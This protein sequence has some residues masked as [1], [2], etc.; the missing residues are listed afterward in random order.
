M[1]PFHFQWIEMV[2]TGDS[3]ASTPVVNRHFPTWGYI[4]PADIN[5]SDTQAARANNPFCL[6]PLTLP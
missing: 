1:N 2:V 4:I 6:F 3:D 5:G